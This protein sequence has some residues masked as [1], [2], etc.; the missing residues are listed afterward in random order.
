MDIVVIDYGLLS[1][2][3]TAEYKRYILTEN[4][5]SPRAFPGDEGKTVVQSGNVHREDGHITEDPDMR[6]AMVEKLMKKIPNIKNALNPPK[7]YG[8]HD[9]KV[10][11]LTWG[12]TWGAANEAIEILSSGGVSINQLHFCDV[13]PLRTEILSKVWDQAEKVVAVEQN[14]TSQFAKLVRMES[15]LT[16]DAHVNKYDGRRM[17]ARWMIKRLEEVGVK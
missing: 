1:S 12:T 10:S 4:G 16:V 2:S 13:F 17:S 15:G 14:V 3:K 8:D 11:L 5:V 9:A 6:N 7:I